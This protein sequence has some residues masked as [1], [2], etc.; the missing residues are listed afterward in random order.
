MRRWK[1]ALSLALLGAVAMPFV[2]GTWQKRY[3]V[4]RLVPLSAEQKIDIADYLKEKDYCRDMER[5]LREEPWGKT[6]GLAKEVN[7]CQEKAGEL[8]RGGNYHEFPSPRDFLIFN[9]LAAIAGFMLVFSLTMLL[10]PL[11]RRYWKWLK[12]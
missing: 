5:R 4:V 11:A 7:A 3:T 12:T 10:P 9:A 6:L 1:V 8:Q 2:W